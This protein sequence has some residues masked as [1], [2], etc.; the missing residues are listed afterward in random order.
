MELCKEKE[1]NEVVKTVKEALA[2]V[3]DMYDINI[4]MKPLDFDLSILLLHIQQIG[5]SNN[6][7]NNSNNNNNNNNNKQTDGNARASQNNSQNQALSNRDMKSV[8][9]FMWVYFW[10]SFYM[11]R[12][13]VCERDFYLAQII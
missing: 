7:N 13:C 12:V 5:T 9:I 1:G 3:P 10:F 8:R 6:N 2:R 4:Q 11:S